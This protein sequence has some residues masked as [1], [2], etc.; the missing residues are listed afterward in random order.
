[1]INQISFMGKIIFYFVFIFL[2]QPIS[3]VAQLN[4]LSATKTLLKDE[5][6]RFFGELSKS[7]LDPKIT[8]RLKHFAVFEIDSIQE[9]ITSDNIN[10]VE[11]EKAIRSLFSFLKVLSNNIY[12]PKL[13]MYDIPGTIEAYK[14]ILR[15]LL[16]HKSI[17]DQLSK[18]SP[19][20]SQSLAKTFSQYSEYNL[21]EDVAV[22]KRVSSSPEYI[23]QFLESNPIELRGIVLDSYLIDQSSPGISN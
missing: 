6:N 23:L 8:S 12:Q 21:L 4:T 17:N 16:H 22:Y 3:T 11:K 2:L 7:Q 19:W 10:E 20:T 14:N 1:M 13:E 15:S 9:A 18:I 5:K